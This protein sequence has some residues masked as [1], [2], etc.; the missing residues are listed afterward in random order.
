MAL[1]YLKN[2]TDPFVRFL[3]AITNLIPE[4][5]DKKMGTPKVGVTGT[6]GADRVEMT[7]ERFNSDDV[8]WQTG[9]GDNGAAIMSSDCPYSELAN[10]ADIKAEMDRLVAEFN[11]SQYQRDRFVEYPCTGDFLEAYTEKEIG[12]DST[13]WD[14]YVTKYNKVK[15]DIPKP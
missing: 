15:T 11:S 10:F 2:N 5:R 1:R 3:W 6:G 13:K 4:F 8:K 9:V 14:E 12:G 7:E